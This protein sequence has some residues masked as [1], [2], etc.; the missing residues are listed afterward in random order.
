MSALI[1]KMAK[2]E[3]GLMV[4]MRGGPHMIPQLRSGGFDCA[5]A[6]MM[7][8]GVDWREFDYFIKS[9]KSCGMTTCVRLPTNPWLAGENNMQLAVDAARAFSLGVDIV[10][11]SVA[12]LAQ[13]KVLVE[14]SRDW[15]R[16]GA[17]WF[18]TS[19]EDFSS[20]MQQS[21]KQA[22]ACASIESLTA[23]KDIDEIVA[24]PGLRILALA[25]T[26]LSN[27][28]GHSFGYDHPEVLALVRNLAEKAKKNGV[29]LCAN[30]GYE[31]ST[32]QEIHDRMQR[33]YDCGARIIL[34]NTIEKLTNTL[35][36]EL[37]TKFRTANG[38]SAD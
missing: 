29:V 24:V 30:I 13:V 11:A 25:C 7:H 15:H 14:T 38:L 17:G 9:A 5:R 26:D 2:G 21:G 18:P 16:S 19:K 28:M 33:L 34:M 8:S 32:A 35:C 1:E 6:D 12:S 31:A 20:N 3:L 27:Q 37:N 36:K 23:L 4:S 22:M 10:K